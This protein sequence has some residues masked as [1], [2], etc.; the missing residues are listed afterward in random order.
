M[1]LLALV[2]CAG[3][4]SSPSHPASA[5][6]SVATSASAAPSGP[7]SL[8]RRCGGPYAPART[9]TLNG[10]GGS[11]LP[12]AEV[13]SG[14][15]VAVFL[16]ESGSTAMCGFWPYAVWLARTQHLRSVLFDMC[17]YGEAQC[18]SASFTRD[19]L[20]QVRL[21]VGWARAHG[22]RRLAVVG[23]SAGG[24]IA[25]ATARA[26]H[27]DAVV[28]LSGPMTWDGLSATRAAPRLTMPTLLAIAPNDMDATLAQ[29]RHLYRLL[30]GQRRLVRAPCCHGWD[31][32]TDDGDWTP[33]ARRVAHW[34]RSP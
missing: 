15:T 26:V 31:M 24:T 28:D 29:Y 11:R 32:L 27:A 14:G 30:P 7:T 1:A 12:A 8:S 10:P 6:P 22:A 21:A 34:I 18:P 3:P 5:S 13:G 19:D 25:L 17:G 23:A 9:F 2:A 16:H 4:S 33:L 20:A